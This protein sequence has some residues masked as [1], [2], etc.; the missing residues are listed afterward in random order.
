M[1]K[2]S[3]LFKFYT[4]LLENQI[5]QLSNILTLYDNKLYHLIPY[6]YVYL[7]KREGI[8][9][10]RGVTKITVNNYITANY[11]GLLIPETDKENMSDENTEN[12]MNFDELRG[13]KFIAK[14]YV[15]EL[16]YGV[17]FEFNKN[18]TDVI[19]NIRIK[20]QDIP[21][22]DYIDLDWIEHTYN[23]LGEKLIE[24]IR[25]EIKREVYM[26]KLYNLDEKSDSIKY[27]RDISMDKILLELYLNLQPKFPDQ[28]ILNEDTM[29]IFNFE[30][31]ESIIEEFTNNLIQDEKYRF[32]VKDIFDARAL[33]I[34]I[35]KL[36]NRCFIT[37]SADTFDILI[38]DASQFLE[39]L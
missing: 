20:I 7:V 12:K 34:L 23:M 28:N 38:D 24:K 4:N 27:T 35:D 13:K 25:G 30:L 36:N 14:F 31:D 9:K 15:G 39:V 3:D 16:P 17:I 18:T 8:I 21:I 37:D 1:L 32:D 22:S 6:K 11:Y 10:Y 5:V 2:E 33:H 19:N 26:F 29:E